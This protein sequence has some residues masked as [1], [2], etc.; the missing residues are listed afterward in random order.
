MSSAVTNTNAGGLPYTGTFVNNF[1]LIGRGQGISLHVHEVVH[2]TINENGDLTAEVTFT[3][4]LE[5]VGFQPD[6]TCLRVDGRATSMGGAS[7]AAGAMPRA[8]RS[9]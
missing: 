8:E 2:A 6:V 7:A 3:G 9:A 4:D 1:R 5:L